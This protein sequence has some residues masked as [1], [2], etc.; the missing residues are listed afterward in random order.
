M[1]ETRTILAPG[2]DGASAGDAAQGRGEAALAWSLAVNS[3]LALGKVLV[4]ALAGSPAL[5]ADGWHSLSDVVTNGVAWISFRIARTPPDEDHHY[6]HGNAES[7]AALLL[8]VV[9]IGGG[10]GILWDALAGSGAT[11]HGALGYAALAVAFVSTGANTWLWR[12]THR[13]ASELDSP[14]LRALARDNGGDVLTG[15]LVVIGIGLSLLGAH[16]V[17]IGVALFIGALVVLMGWRSAR[18]GF[19]VL[20]DRVADPDLR[21]RLRGRA[22][23]VEGVRSVQAVRV[24]PVGSVYRVDMEIRVDGSL[25]VREGHAIAH[26]VESSIIGTLARVAEVQVHVEPARDPHPSPSAP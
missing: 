2:D 12:L 7:A 9:L 16:W 11:R 22:L 15:V 24:H 5:L 18:E 1:V 21:A 13:A 6:G 19:D 10:G 23:G 25:T 4:G 17:E 8:G 20:M 26:A 14:S 3:A